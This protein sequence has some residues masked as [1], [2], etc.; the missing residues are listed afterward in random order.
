MSAEILTSDLRTQ[1]VELAARAMR[2]APWTFQLPLAGCGVS[3]RMRYGTCQARSG[4][5][6]AD[7]HQSMSQRA[8]PGW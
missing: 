3:G 7:P 1:I 8:G 5:R 2:C 6:V 4:C